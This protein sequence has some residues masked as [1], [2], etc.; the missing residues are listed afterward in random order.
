MHL[1]ILSP[2]QRELLP[3]IARFRR[4]YYLVGGTAIA[5]HI[6]HRQSID[7]DLF[8]EKKIR[9]HSIYKKIKSETTTINPGYEDNE[10]LNLIVNDVKLTFFQYHYSIPLNSEVENIIKMPDLLTLAAMKALALGRRAKWKDYVDLYFLLRYHF[11]LEEIVVKAEKIFGV[12]FSK[13]LFTMQLGFF[14][15]IN[16]EERVTFLVDNPPTKAEIQNF[17]TD[18]SL[19]DL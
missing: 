14:K 6:G 7:F 15:G 12:E 4:E 9:K 8:R 3:L 5:L 1:D 18:A 17:L 11:T 2:G 10:Q 16:Y 13:K 19:S